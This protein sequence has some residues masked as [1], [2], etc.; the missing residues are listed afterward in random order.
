MQTLLDRQLRQAIDSWRGRLARPQRYRFDYDHILGTSLELQ[1]VATSRSA[2]VRAESAVL[3]EVDR[4]ESILSGWSGTSELARWL[5]THDV[6]VAISAELAEVLDA[7]AVW[8]ERTARAFDPGAQAIIEALRDENRDGVRDAAP[9]LDMQSLLAEL[10][11]PLWN[12]D[13]DALTARRLTRHA[14]S[15][16]AIAKGYIV[17][18]A[19]AR[20]RDVA[21]VSEVLLNIGGDIQHFGARPVAIGIAD[22][23]APAENAPPIAMVRIANAA[24]ATSG[25]YRRGFVANGERV[26]HIV[27]PRSGRPASKIA[28]ASVFAPDCATADAL[29]TAFSVMD[30][31]ESVLFADAI[32]G[33]GCL[34]VTNDGVITTN[35][36]WDG[37]ATA[38]PDKSNQ[39][40]E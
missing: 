19:A 1:V 9:R 26:S 12:V 22:P 6:D 35:A 2:A 31:R 5:A 37:H 16:D 10:R 38:S 20:A 33:V 32:A 36:T 14:I 13:R 4:L 40:R 30:P 21:G 3:A 15:L 29:S 39:S 11:R 8:R 28:S 18:R 34:L 17:S 25:G 23:S 7:G 24:L 27:D